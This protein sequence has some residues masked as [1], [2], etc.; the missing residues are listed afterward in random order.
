MSFRKKFIIDFDSTFT[1]VEALDILGEICLANDPEK[2]SKLEAIT[3]IT[4]SGMEGQLSFRESLDARIALLS[5]HRKHLPEL[6]ERLQQRVSKSFQINKKFIRKYASDIHIVSNGFKEFIIPVVA[7]FG[8]GPDHVHANT[9]VFDNHD[10]IIGFDKENVLS[11]NGGKSKV[12]EQLQ[13][14]GTICVIGDGFTDYE[15]RAAGV[16]QTFYAFTE[17]VHRSRVVSF[18]DHVAPSLDEILYINKMER[19]ISYP[20]SRLNVLV[21]E[22]IHQNAIDFFT[23]EGYNVNV[24][25]GALTEAELMNVI[26]DVSILCIRSKTQVTQAVL[27]HAKRLHLIGAFCIGT[28]QIDLHAATQKGIAVFNAPFSNTRSVVELAIAEIIFLLRNLTDRIFEMRN[29]LWNKLATSSYEIRG[30]KLGIIGYGN[31]GA[32]L[33]VLAENL[34]LDVYFYDIDEKLPL[35][36]ATKVYH[37][38]TL[39]KTVD[40]VSVHV[41]GR[42]ENSQLIGASEINAMKPGSYFLNLSRGSVVDLDA[43]EAALHNGHIAG[44]AIDVFPDEPTK[45]GAPFSHSI[46][47]AKN[48]I[49]TPHIG[50]STLEAQ[51]D[52]ARFVPQKLVDFINTGNTQNTVNFPAIQLPFLKEAHRLIHIHKNEPGVLAKINQLFASSNSNIVGQYLKTNEQIGYVITDID[53]VYD[54]DL[55]KQLRNIS[56]TLKF[57][58]LY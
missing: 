8:I 16:A 15:M 5:A 56:G 24:V 32:Q 28:N 49:L 48:V 9:F 19:K 12:L 27:E 39:L 22:N 57:R 1:Q 29:G 2:V 46:Q 7:D 26:E 21:L 37:L 45:N 55:L 4:N 44:A 43:L 10:N 23:D 35:G 33:S 18:A 13:L 41:D 11:K 6:V 58:V 25:S 51:E 20:K 40:I 17:N 47:S 52:I 31:I 42:P 34:G 38:E 53:K 54:K 3:N 30:K 36:N 50:G 14:K